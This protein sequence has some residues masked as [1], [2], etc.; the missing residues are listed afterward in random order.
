MK[1]DQNCQENKKA[2]KIFI[3]FVLVMG[4]L[5]GAVGYLSTK[6]FA[7]SLSK[8]IVEMLEEGL[9]F[10]SPCAV[11]LLSAGSVLTGRLLFNRSRRAYQNR[12]EQE[13]EILDQIE[14]RISDSIMIVN[15]GLI[16]SLLFFSITLPY[17]ESYIEVSKILYIVML[18]VFILGSIMGSRMN[19][20]QIDFIKTINPKMKGSV[21]DMRFRKKW[22]ESC[23]ELEKLIIYKAS[24]KAYA[25]ANTACFAG[26]ILLTLLSLFFDYGPLPVIIVFAI[27]I[28][29]MLAYYRECRRLEHGKINE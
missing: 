20:L 5:G 3:P 9:Y 13:E 28:T 1:N 29:S 27:W 24:Y 17:I 26:W 8:R 4:C 7:L 2:L 25:A 23:D 11:V 16:G 14:K 19:Q 6:E 10:I 21:Y 22:E 12:G 18:L 15:M